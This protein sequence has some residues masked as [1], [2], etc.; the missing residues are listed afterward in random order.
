MSSK[1]EQREI[2][3]N[4][5]REKANLLKDE[6]DSARKLSWLSKYEAVVSFAKEHGHLKIPWTDPKY[7]GLR[8]WLRQQ[9]NRTRL[10][11]EEKG[12][13]HALKVYSTD[14]RSIEQ[15]RREEWDAMYQALNKFYEINEHFVVPKEDK[16]LY[17]WLKNQRQNYQDNKLSAERKRTLEDLGIPLEGGEK[18]NRKRKFTEKQVEDWNIMFHCLEDFY[19]KFGHCRVPTK[20]DLE[21]SLPEWIKRQRQ[22]YR[23][24][25]IDK[26]R[27]TRL[28]SLEFP[29]TLK[30]NERQA[31]SV[32]K[33]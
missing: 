7:E 8:D 9:S 14:D 31:T 16:S 17:N 13:L 10:S 33:K 19:H 30:G 32:H 28:E 29:W 1:Y 4:Y 15:K 25:K 18:L 6:R 20:Y 24:G 5:E 22:C 2:D 23:L 3:W 11:V 12:L 27:Q 26:D 21:P